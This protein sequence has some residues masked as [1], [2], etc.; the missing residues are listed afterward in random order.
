MFSFRI[1]GFI[2]VPGRAY[3]WVSFAQHY[4]S[5]I[6][7]FSLSTFVGWTRLPSISVI[8]IQLSFPPKSGSNLAN[9]SSFFPL[10]WNLSTSLQIKHILALLFDFTVVEIPHCL[11]RLRTSVQEPVGAILR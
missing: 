10:S 3:L 1:P 9:L 8:S 2:C 5:S 7:M 4:K 6:K 11:S